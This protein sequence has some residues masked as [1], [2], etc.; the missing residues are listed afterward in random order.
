MPIFNFIITVINID[1]S[2]HTYTAGIMEEL[3]VHYA[4]ALESIRILLRCSTAL[5]IYETVQGDVLSK[6]AAS[7]I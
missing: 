6:L 1:F 4:A 3:N 2:K 7:L 5:L